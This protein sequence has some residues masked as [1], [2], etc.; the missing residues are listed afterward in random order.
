LLPPLAT[1]APIKAYV[2]L[3]P[4]SKAIKTNEI[5]RAYL[6][7]GERKLVKFKADSAESPGW[8]N[9][10]LMT[11]DT[12]YVFSASEYA[13]AVFLACEA[14]FR[15]RYGVRTP[16]SAIEY[17]KAEWRVIIEIRARLATRRFYNGRPAD[18][19]PVPE[20]LLR[21]DVPEALR[22]VASKL[23]AFQPYAEAPG[24]TG[25]GHID[26]HWVA[27]WLRQFETDEAI[28]CALRMLQAMKALTREEVRLAV[29]GFLTANPEFKGCHVCQ[30]GGRVTVPRSSPTSFK[31]S[32]SGGT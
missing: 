9:A 12:D 8:S 17:S 5:A 21:A 26:E 25:G 28:E 32:L 3:D 31:T 10:Y 30:F 7:T 23:R 27:A 11:R 18:L 14:V 4:F 24:A 6:M 1:D 29:D 13:P 20:R 22:A 2:A 16:P 19:R 15:R